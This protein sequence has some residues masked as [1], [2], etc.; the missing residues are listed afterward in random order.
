MMYA[1]PMAALVLLGLAWWWGSFF[2]RVW[3]TFVWGGP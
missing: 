2:G 1:D 3:A